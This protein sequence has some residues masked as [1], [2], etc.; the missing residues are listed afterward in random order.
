[1]RMNPLGC[2][3][4]LDPLTALMHVV[5]VMN[6]LKM[7]IIRKL[8]DRQEEVALLIKEDHQ[9]RPG[10]ALA[11]T[12][13]SQ[14]DEHDEPDSSD[15]SRSVL[16]TGHQKQYQ[17]TTSAPPQCTADTKVVY[18]ENSHHHHHHHHHITIPPNL[19]CSTTAKPHSGKLV[20]TI[21]TGVW[22]FCCRVSRQLFLACKALL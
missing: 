4:I 18:E 8:R 12:T 15:S 17:Y 3:Q 22:S 21:S 13:N 20:N 10:T 9:H 7:L 1:M 11:E 5:Q 14:A 2:L 16:Q 19:K 6:L